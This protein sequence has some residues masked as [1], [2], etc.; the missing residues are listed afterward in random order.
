MR[1]HLDGCKLYQDSEGVPNLTLVSMVFAESMSST[2][3]HTLDLEVA[4]LVYAG[5]RPLSMLDEPHM[6]R[7]LAQ[8]RSAYVPPDRKLLAGRLLDKVYEQLKDS[9]LT[10]LRQQPF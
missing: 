8:L 6:R 2:T 1:R 7:L 10:I 9:V 5:G 3:K 4:R